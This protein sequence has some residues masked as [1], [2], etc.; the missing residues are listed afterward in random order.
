[1]KKL[2]CFLLLTAATAF[3]S[4]E[5]KVLHIF[6]PSYAE[7]TKNSNFWYYKLNAKDDITEE[8]I[9]QAKYGE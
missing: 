3:A 4:N 6:G 7:N 5:E 8:D 9:F 2:I 1:M